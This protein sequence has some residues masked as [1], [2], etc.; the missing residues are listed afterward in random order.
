MYLCGMASALPFQVKESIASLKQRYKTVASH[1]K[2]KVQMLLIVKQSEVALT[3]NELAT[4]VGVN[5]NSIQSWRKKYLTFGIDDLL[6]DGRG[7]YKPSL[8]NDKQKEKV[9]V[10]ISSPTDAFSSFKELQTWVNTTFK[11]EVKYNSL[12]LFVKRNFGAKMKIARKSHILK[13]ENKVNTFKKTSV[14]PA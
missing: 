6:T 4:L 1:H 14:K 9:L 11:T 5:H 12:R 8:L 3:K 2:Q 7:G 13:D 10:R